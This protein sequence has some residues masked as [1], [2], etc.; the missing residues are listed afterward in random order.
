MYLFR[1][2][3]LTAL[4][5]L[6]PRNAWAFSN[7]QHNGHVHAGLHEKRLLGLLEGLGGL[8]GGGGPGGSGAAIEVTGEH[9][10]QAPGP[11][12]QRG[13]CPGLNAMANH[14][15]IPRNGVVS[16]LGA[17]N[18][19]T[20]VVNMS[21][22][23]ALLLAVM[24]VVW[25]GNPVSLDPS[26]SIGGT[27]PEVQNLLGNALGLLGEPQ[28]IDHSHNFIEA[29]SSPTRDD[30]YVTNDPVTMNL[31]KFE[32]LYDLIPEGQVFTA[33]VMTDFAMI[34]WNE[35]VATNPYFYYGPV[36]GMIARNTGYCFMRNLFANYSSGKQ[37]FTHEIFKSWY[38]VTGDRD[39][40]TYT[41]GHERIPANLV[42]N[43]APYGLVNLNLDIVA[44]I[45]RYPIF[46]S[47]GGNTGE[48]NSFTGVNLGD[49]V[50]GVL[51]VPRLL[52]GNNLLCFALEVVNFAAPNYLNNLVS[53]LAAPL[54]M[55]TDAIAAPLLNMSCPQLG[56]ITRDGKPLWQ[57]LGEEFP[58][59]N[60]S[61]SA[62]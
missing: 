7:L 38:S 14:G 13:P 20:S 61:G 16:L 41:K 6:L 35:T 22:E 48:V 25:T 3:L 39:D 40:F 18:A 24:G 55:L 49:P 11:G 47:I 28:G 34:R 52:E 19:I 60:K 21:V 8:G 33:E 9:E 59:A 29:D 46:G 5:S 58:G 17:V 37:E 54:K 56:E 32:T 57:S 15:Y 53:T 36:T 44:M 10:W 4:V 26:F 27:T 23:L 62:M 42:P 2:Q 30:L 43:P 12:D 45:L 50:D 1:V 51:N 31:T